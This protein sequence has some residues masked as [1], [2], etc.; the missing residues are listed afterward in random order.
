MLLASLSQTM[1]GTQARP[2]Q[3]AHRLLCGIWYPNSAQFPSVMK[4]CRIVDIPTVGLDAIARR[5]RVNGAASN[6]LRRFTVVAV[7]T[8]PE[9]DDVLSSDKDGVL[10][11]IAFKMCIFLSMMKSWSS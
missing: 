10:D 6:S 7:R 4:P 2:N 8:V 11:L 1:H 3:I 5:W 9:S